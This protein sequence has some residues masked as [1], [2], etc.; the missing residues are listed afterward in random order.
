M[1]IFKILLILG[2]RVPSA[3]HLLSCLP[4]GMQ[5]SGPGRR[6]TLSAVADQRQSRSSVLSSNCT[7]GAEGTG[8]SQTHPGCTPSHPIA[9]W[10]RSPRPSQLTVYRRPALSSKPLGLHT[11]D[12]WSPLSPISGRRHSQQ[13]ACA[14][15]AFPEFP[16]TAPLWGPPQAGQTPQA[17]KASPWTLAKPS[18]PSSPHLCKPAS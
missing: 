3:S 16:P 7:Q 18:L 1:H 6:V 12:V 14:I 11:D 13:F 10:Q 15:L 5:S 9:S 17:C 4:L 8:A 2:P